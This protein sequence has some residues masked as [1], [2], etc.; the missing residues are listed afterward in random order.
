M[1]SKWG[2]SKDNRTKGETDNYMKPM[3]E[4][5][6]RENPAT[7]NTID[8]DSKMMTS[9][10]TF[11]TGANL[12]TENHNFKSRDEI[13]PSIKQLKGNDDVSSLKA[14]ELG[15][16]DEMKT[17]G[18]KPSKSP[19]NMRIARPKSGFKKRGM[20]VDS[21]SDDG[22]PSQISDVPNSSRRQRRHV[23]KANDVDLEK[24]E[25]PSQG[26]GEPEISTQNRNFLVLPVNSV[27]PSETSVNE[28]E[29]VDKVDPTNEGD[30]G[31]LEADFP[32]VIEDAP[33]HTPFLLRAIYDAFEDKGDD[34]VKNFRKDKMPKVGK[35]EIPESPKVSPEI[36]AE[37]S[38]KSLKIEG[39]VS[40]EQPIMDTP[41]KTEGDIEMGNHSSKSQEMESSESE[42]DLDQDLR[43]S[44][45][46][47]DMYGRTEDH[48]NF[49]KQ[50]EEE[51]HQNSDHN[52][53]ESG[54]SVE[55]EEL[56]PSEIP[57]TEPSVAFGP[58]IEETK[59]EQPAKDTEPVENINQKEPEGV[60]LPPIHRS[61]K[62]IDA[63]IEA[64]IS[65]VSNSEENKTFT[66]TQLSTTNKAPSK[67]SKS[68]P[69]RAK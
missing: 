31:R 21:D 36:K 39:P 28:D 16:P 18:K 24:G 37:D 45:K 30:L 29:G 59:S 50:P 58:L 27:K 3:S 19:L 38:P 56:R 35:E 32:N 49:G 9:K 67:T 42:E 63:P 69:S 20:N 44:K 51:K 12:D 7:L 64:E 5:F 43:L 60:I 47:V 22:L 25:D 8:Q 40:T 61:E 46:D 48:P 34:V 53:G 33:E 41:R 66:E 2:S 10:P 26:F 6:D 14:K 23:Q 11:D 57:P 68:R 4:D 65:S 17:S 15:Q 62:Q 52:S 54:E 1:S 13:I 55:Y